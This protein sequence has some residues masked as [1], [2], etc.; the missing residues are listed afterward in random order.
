MTLSRRRPSLAAALLAATLITVT[1]C[2]TLQIT[3]EK[4]VTAEPLLPEATSPAALVSPAPD[5]RAAQP[6]VEQQGEPI[7]VVAWYGRVHSVDAAEPGYDYLK[8]WYLNLWPK[9]GPAVGLTGANP[10]IDAE[11]ER[12]R[13]RDIGAHFWGTL[14]CGVADYG[15]CQLR[16]TRLSANDGGPTFNPDPVEGWSGTLGRL[17]V[18]PG[19]QDESL[20]FS[21][22]GEIPV[23]YS[24]ISQDPAIQSELE[25]LI[26]GESVIRIWGELH[27]RVNSVTGSQI[28]V[29]RLEI[30]SEM[31]LP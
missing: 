13:D 11:I 21:L 29:D 9:L 28:T 15:A 31:P 22:A 20:Y 23:L 1:A 12:I 3:V 14:T 4:T 24:I 7:E 26:P 8:P 17:P 30:L 27:N 19:S 10:A 5:G 16:V 25:R 2:G 6:S 18:Q